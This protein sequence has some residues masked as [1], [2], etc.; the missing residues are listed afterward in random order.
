MF[1]YID[2][3]TRWLD[4]IPL[5]SITAKQ[6][7]L[8]MLDIFSRTGIPLEMLTDQRSQFVARLTKELC[9]LLGVQKLHTTPYHPQTNGTLE[10]F[11]GT[12]E[13]MLTK[14]K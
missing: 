3:A 1:T 8:G 5:C 4:A 9:T 10:R 7:A 12:L 6:V 14:A 13:A 11:H 2:L